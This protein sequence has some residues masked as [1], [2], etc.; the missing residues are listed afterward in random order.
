M[1]VSHVAW[2]VYDGKRS[3]RGRVGIK[4]DEFSSIFELR[5][6]CGHSMPVA[7]LRAVVEG[8]L[9]EAQFAAAIAKQFSK[10]W[11]IDVHN[12]P[13]GATEYLV[14]IIE[15]PEWLDTPII[16]RLHVSM[17]GKLNEDVKIWLPNLLKIFP[18]VPEN[19]VYF[20]ECSLRVFERTP[21]NLTGF[22]Y[23]ETAS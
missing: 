16:S 4:Y 18:L 13:S 3:M 1:E 11:R 2:S 5:T 22:T 12:R 20:P 7:L 10:P 23:P 17:Y 14:R 19:S 6:L 9:T 8:V 21:E 15:S